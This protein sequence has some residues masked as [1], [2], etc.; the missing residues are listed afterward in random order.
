M[1]QEVV[2]PPPPP[3]SESMGVEGSGSGLGSVKMAE[4]EKSEVKKSIGGVRGS[5]CEWV[6]K[7]LRRC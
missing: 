7:K 1:V 4:M 5:V 3:P 6:Y 2:P